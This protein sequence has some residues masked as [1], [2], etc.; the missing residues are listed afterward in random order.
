MALLLTIK[1]IIFFIFGACIGS[2]VNV[3]ALRYGTGLSFFRG[4]SF[5]FSCNEKLGFI[6]LIPIFSF[7]FLRGKCRYCHSVIPKNLLFSEIIMGFLSVCAAYKVGFLQTGLLTNFNVSFILD[8]L[9]LVSLFAIV[10]LITI[11]D[12][13][14]LIIPDTFLIALLLSSFVYWFP[15]LV[16]LERVASGVLLSLPFLLIFYISRG[17][18]MGFGDIKYIALI[19]YMFG[20][21]QGVSVVT[22][23][24]WI[25]ALVSVIILSLQKIRDKRGLHP[26][27]NKITIKSEI[28]FGP[29]LSVA[30]IFVVIFNINVY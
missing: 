10:F 5:C 13:K 4:R 7:L 19:G 15:L 1:I 25:G 12:I 24:F 23:S 21:Y 6:D 22:L 20:L 3:V 16:S 17:R 2:F 11:Y 26:Y 14:H 9:S 18:W 27:F 30:I 8:Y 28:P 29:F